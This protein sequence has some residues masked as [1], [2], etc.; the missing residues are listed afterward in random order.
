MAP[1]AENAKHVI[2]RS[3]RSNKKPPTTNFTRGCSECVNCVLLD[4]LS[5]SILQALVFS[6]FHPRKAQ[7]NKGLL[8]VRKYV[9]KIKKI[10]LRRDNKKRTTIKK[11]EDSD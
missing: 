9:E 8:S 4:L 7:N 5:V 6:S 1:A 3:R 2:I 10:L 11:T